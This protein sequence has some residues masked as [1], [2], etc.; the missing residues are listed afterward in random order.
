MPEI[1]RRDELLRIT[2]GGIKE[3]VWKYIERQAGEKSVA[4]FVWRGFVLLFF[5]CIPTVIGSLMRTMAYKSLLGSIGSNCFIEKKIRL[6]AP[7]RIFLGDRV[8][9]GEDSTIDAGVREKDGR[10]SE[11]RIGDDVHLPRY[12]VLKAGPGSIILGNNICVGQFSWLDGSGGLEIGSD[13]RMASHCS[14]ISANHGYKKKVLL[15][16]QEKIYEKVKIGKDVW[17]GSHVVVLP[18]VTIGDGCVVGAGAVVTKDLPD[19]SVA[20]GVPA[21]VINKRE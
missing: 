4:R 6:T 7:H 9:I 17:L 13:S 16:S 21:R 2:E 5:S 10:S 19:Y 12:C 14:I 11:I 3:N 1:E 8:A 18:G 20:V 15:R